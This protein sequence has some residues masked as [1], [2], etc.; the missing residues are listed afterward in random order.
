VRI[1]PLVLVALALLVPRA[2]AQD[3]D[4]GY[5]DE[6][7]EVAAP[8]A[9]EAPAPGDYEDA[10]VP[11]GSW[12]DDDQYGRV[13]EPGVSIGWEPYVDGYWA[14]TPY[15]WTWV[16]AEPWSWTFHYGRWV[17]LPAGW[18]WV[19]GNV[20]GPAW[21]D[22]Y[23]GD[24]YVGWAPLPPF[25][26]QVTV[27][28]TFVFVHDRDFC[29]RNLTAVAVNHHLV[30]DQVIH[31]WGD[32]NGRPPSLHQIERVSQHGITRFDQRP[33]GTLPPRRFDRNR[34]RQVQQAESAPRRLGA[35][36][37]AGAART[38]RPG[39]ATFGHPWEPQGPARTPEIARRTNPPA[40]AFA[41]A[42]AWPAR[43]GGRP[44]V[45]R[46]GQVQRM[47]RQAPPAPG[48]HGSFVPSAGRHGEGAGAHGSTFVGTPPGGH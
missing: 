43:A 31:G 27:I 6:G 7:D 39:E 22:W 8:P 3:Y 38:L 28:N 36:W 23:W 32:R 17:P 13:W 30:P 19:P 41:P 9:D 35:A 5:A 1:L 37:Q 16:S 21:V 46:G 18:A 42:P 26:T 10:L 47:P 33:P 15:G 12:I 4:E 25:A 20:W 2:H 45:A 24:G 48:A 44:N 14:W 40:P 11:Y 34:P 29:S